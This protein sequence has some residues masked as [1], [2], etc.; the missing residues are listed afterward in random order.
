MAGTRCYSFETQPTQIQQLEMGLEE[1]ADRLEKLGFSH[2]VLLERK[3]H[4]RRIV[5]MLV[6]RSTSQWHLKSGDT[7][8]LA[9][10]ELDVERLLLGRGSDTKRRSLVEHLQRE[11]ESLSEL[12]HVLGGRRLLCLTY[13]GDLA[14]S[15]EQTYRR[16]CDFAGLGYHQVTVPFGKTNPFKLRDIVIN[17]SDVER[18][19]RGT[20]FEW[21]LYS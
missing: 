13:E 14:A 19:L 17:F 5:S 4:L 11:Q 21:M 1:Y 9:R 10:I 8:K 15:P 16:V 2:F 12:K 18:V 7:P 6:A 20:S 3:N